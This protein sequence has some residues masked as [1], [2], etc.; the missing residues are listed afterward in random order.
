MIEIDVRPEA[1]D[2]PPPNDRRIPVQ[3]YGASAAKDMGAIGGSVI[4]RVSRIAA[5]LD[6]AAFDFLSLSLS[7]AVAAA[8]TFADRSEAA[9]GWAREIN[10]VVAL[11]DPE[12]WRPAQS[13]LEKALRFLSGDQWSLRFVEGGRP[14]PAP[15]TRV[16]NKLVLADCRSA[17]LF[18]GGLDSAIGMLDLRAEGERSVLI[19]HAYTHD[20]GRQAEILNRAG[21]ATPRLA[22]HANPTK[23]LDHNNDVRMR[24]RS[25]N[26]FAMGA[27]V[28]ATLSKNYLQGK[29]VPLYVPENGLIAINS[30]LTNRRIGALSTRTTHPHYMLLIQQVFDA[31]GLPVRLHNPYATLTKGEMIAE[32]ADQGALRSFVSRTVSCGK[33]KRSGIQCGRCVPCL[34]RRASLYHAG[35][36]DQTEYK[37]SSKNLREVLK[38]GNDSDDLMAMILAARRMDSRDVSSWIAKTGPLPKDAAEQKAL[39]DVV[40]RGMAEVA[41]YLRSEQ[42]PA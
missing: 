11:A 36:E 30:P 23:R 41:Q 1:A 4:D 25:F 13:L 28:A 17:C 18:W 22:L 10:L 40:S 7:L 8:D 24:T 39:A 35:W 21:G 42:L 19:S 37:A 3:L 15:R 26:F 20:A 12:R 38:A 9:D 27:L 29:A 16:S 5:P 34:I 2:L 6:H 31:V 32:C 14:L 33:W